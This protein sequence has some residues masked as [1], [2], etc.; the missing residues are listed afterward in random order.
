MRSL[1]F[2]PVSAA[3]LLGAGALLSSKTGQTTGDGAALGPQPLVVHL[4]L[5]SGERARV[6]GGPPATHS[7]RSGYVVL[8]PGESVGKHTTGGYEEVLVVFEGKGKMA[9]AGGPE[10]ILERGSV[11]YCP[12]QREHDVTNTGPEPLRY[13]YIV[14]TALPKTEE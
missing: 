7:M 4:D 11:A 6:L 12:P 2:V 5:S 8:A 14:A 13:V 1:V 10:L 3:L 9:I